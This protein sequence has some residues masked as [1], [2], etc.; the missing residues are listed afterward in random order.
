MSKGLRTKVKTKLVIQN[1]L[2]EPKRRYQASERVIL[3]VFLSRDAVFRGRTALIWSLFPHAQCPLEVCPFFLVPG[4][5]AKV[6]WTLGFCHSVSKSQALFPLPRR[7]SCT[8]TLTRCPLLSSLAGLGISHKPSGS[9]L[10]SL[11]SEVF[12]SIVN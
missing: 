6:C 12:C 8:H 2:P 4:T 1:D 9:V 10:P 3:T 5:E 11:Y 7:T